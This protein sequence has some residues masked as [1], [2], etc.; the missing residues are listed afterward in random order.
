MFAKFASLTLFALC[1]TALVGHAENALGI[2]TNTPSQPSLSNPRT[3]TA[4]GLKALDEGLTTEAIAAFERVLA[5][6][7]D[8]MAVRTELARAYALLG[9]NVAAAREL[10]TVT[11]SPHTPSS[12]K[13]NLNS[14]TSLLTQSLR[15]GPR[16]YRATAQIGIGADSN[17]NTATNSSYMVLP[18]LAALGPAKL[19]DTAQ[20]KSSLFTETSVNLTVRQ[21]LSPAWA[22]YAGADASHKQAFTSDSFNQSTLSAETGIQHSSPEGRRLT[23]GLSARQFWYGNE[24]YSQTY[25]VTGNWFQPLGIHTALSTY[26]SAAQTHYPDLSAQD[27]DR[28]TFGSTLHAYYGKLSAYAGLYGGTESAKAALN[29]HDF[30]GTTLGAEYLLLPTLSTYTEAR[31]EA[32]DYEGYN[33]TFLTT[34]EDRQLDLSIGLSYALS[35]HFSLRPSIGYRS[36]SS[37]IPM[38]D[39]T[40]W[41]TLIA[42]RYTRP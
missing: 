18:A 40:R 35:S 6:E 17:I 42:L 11:T 5:V 8:N 2:V 23:L 14:Y 19:D 24:S 25:A 20:A 37:N 21:P 22:V 28:L 3:N 9:D 27:A 16:T 38:A 13:D 31:Y 12:I 39:Y 32:R 7:P 34:R 26:A 15:G 30:L 33:P 29:S 10:Q 41:Q 4:H 1:F 36:A